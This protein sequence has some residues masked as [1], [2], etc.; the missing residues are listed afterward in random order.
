[1]KQVCAPYEEHFQRS[2]PPSKRRRAQDI[3]VVTDSSN[4][5]VVTPSAGCEGP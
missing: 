1:M 2:K 3:A 4:S 5:L